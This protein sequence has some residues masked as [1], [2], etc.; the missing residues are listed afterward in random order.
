[1]TW[2]VSSALLL[3]VFSV[4]LL[5]LPVSG[6]WS[7]R[8]LS[9]WQRLVVFRLGKVLP[10]RGPGWTLVL[11]GVDTAQLVDLRNR[12][13]LV[14]PQQLLT[15]DGAVTELGAEVLYR[16]C[17]AQTFV[18]SCVDPQASLRSLCRT[19]LVNTLTSLELARL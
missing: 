6:W 4:T 15:C 1:M 5:T 2:L 14:P 12:S 7:L 11:P 10:T 19:V 8:R 9:Q 16:V 17:D 13:I 18:G 3:A